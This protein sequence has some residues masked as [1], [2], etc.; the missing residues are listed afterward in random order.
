MRFGPA[1]NGLRAWMRTA[2]GVGLD[3]VAKMAGH[4]A[5][6]WGCP[7]VDVTPHSP[8]PLLL[9]GFLRDPPGTAWA[10]TPIGQPLVDW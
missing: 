1:A 7:R 9:R 5:N 6:A 2:P 4:L 8:G 3:Q 10:V